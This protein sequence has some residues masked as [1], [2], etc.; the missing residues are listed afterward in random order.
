MEPD[1]DQPTHVC[2]VEDED[3]TWREKLAD[4][5]DRLLCRIFGH[6]WRR[7][8]SETHIVTGAGEQHLWCA[9]CSARKTEPI[10]P[11]KEAS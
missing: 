2:G 10:P 5:W 4:W 6:L 3:L 8:R 7:G 1:R 11:R 9:R